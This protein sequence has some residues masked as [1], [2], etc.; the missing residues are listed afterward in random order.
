MSLI[1]GFSYLAIKIALESFSPLELLSYR[2]LLAAVV[3]ALLALAKVIKIN[4]KGKPVRYL[5]YLSIFEPVLYFAFETMGIKL[6]SSSEAG[7]FVALNPVFVTIL[8]V[9]FLKEKPTVK[10][11]CFILTS[12]AGVLFILFMSGQASLDGHFVGILFLVGVVLSA[13]GYNILCRKSSRIFTPIEI[14]FVMMWVAAVVFNILRIIQDLLTGHESSA[15]MIFTLKGGISLLYLGILCS[16]AAF[17]LLNYLLSKL[18]VARASVFSNLT[19]VVAILAGVIIGKEAFYWHEIIGGVMILAGV[20]GTNYFA[21]KE[22]EESPE[23][24]EVQ[25]ETD[26]GL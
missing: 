23:S 26:T 11:F 15:A 13:G 1:F 12:V 18:T 22:K 14:T 21:A 19:T 6:T 4:L 10:Q 16:I 25:S 24:E 3:L 5:I 2:F 9:F 20:W 7:L 17:F 8:A